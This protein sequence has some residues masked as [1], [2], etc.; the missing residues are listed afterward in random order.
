M[1]RFLFGC[2]LLIFVNST[3]AQFSEVRRCP[4]LNEINNA[5]DFY[6]THAND[7]IQSDWM[8]ISK[9][10]EPIIYHIT[11]ASTGW[12]AYMKTRVELLVYT[13][14]IVV[15]IPL[16]D[17]Y[18][19]KNDELKMGFRFYS[20]GASRQFIKTD[21]T[22]MKFEEAYQFYINELKNEGEIEFGLHPDCSSKSSHADSKYGSEND[23]EDGGLW[24]I[25]IGALSVALIAGIIKRRKKR[26]VKKDKKDKDKNEQADYI[27]QLNKESFNLNLDKSQ[28][29]QVK[30]WKITE[31]GK[32]L[33]NATIKL[34]CSEKALQMMP[35]SNTGILNSQLTLKEIPKN[36]QFNIIVTATAGGQTIQ[37][38]VRI[39][40][41]VE[42]KI[43]LETY[44]D[45]SRSLRPNTNQTISCY[46]KVV[47]E[48][49]ENID[50]LSQA[51]QFD[52]SYSDWLDLSKPVWDD[53]GWKAINI[54]A[55]NPDTN[56]YDPQTPKSVTLGV[57]VEYTEDGKDKRLENN[58]KIQLLDCKIDTDIEDI[59]FVANDK[60]QTIV[61]NAFIED[62]EE[63]KDWQ[64][65]AHYMKDYETKDAKPLSHISI[66]PVTETKVEIT[67]TGPIEVP[68]DNK[69]YLR[70]ML[71]IS[72][73]QKDEDPLQRELYVMV[74]K[75][76]LYIEE[77]LNEERELSFIAKGD[78]ERDIEFGLYKY[79]S[80]KEDV[81]S[82]EIGL[83][84]LSFELLNKKK[85]D[86]NLASVLEVN[87]E[88]LGLVTTIPR[89]RYTLNAPAEIPG[90]G[91]I[92]DL[93]YRVKAPNTEAEKKPELF[94]TDIT[95][96][97]QTLN[98]GKRYPTWQEAYDDCKYIIDKYVPA[99]PPQ[100]KLRAILEQRKTLLDAQGLTELRKKMW[101]VAYNLILAEGAE[102]YKD[103]DAW[104]SAI[105][106]TLEWTQWAGDI[107]FNVLMAIYFKKFGAVGALGAT[108]ASMLK[109]LMVEGIIFYA[110]EK[111]SA[112]DFADQQYQ[113]IVPLLMNVAKGRLISVDNIAYFVKNNRP[114]AWA[115]FISIEFVYNLWQTKSMIEAAKMT[116]RQIRDEYIIGKLTNHIIK[117]PKKIGLEIAER[118]KKIKYESTRVKKTLDKLEA[119]VRKN[120]IG[121]KFM[122]KGEVL[123]IMK[124]PAMVRTI[125]EHGTTTLKKAFDGPRKKIYQEHDRNLRRQIAKQEG[126]SA[127][128]LKVDDFRTPGTKGYNLNTDRDY[129]LLRRYKMANGKDV[130]LEVPR[131]KWLDKSYKELGKL[132]RKPANVSDRQWAEQL[133]QRGTDKYDAE[134]CADYSDHAI[135]PKTGK[136]IRIKPNILDVEAGK[137]TLIDPDDMGRMY[138]Q[139]VINAGDTP[140]AFAQAKKG[141]HTIKSVRKGY[142]KQG[143]KLK[144]LDPKLERAMRIIENQKVTVD[145]TPS[146]MAHTKKLLNDLG[147][148]NG[149][150]E[151]MDQISNEFKALK[152]VNKNS[153]TERFTNFLFN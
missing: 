151:V 121:G 136:K 127:R 40:T 41:G 16:H 28:Q 48:N 84:N 5:L 147:Y 3:R 133:Q 66:K 25:V 24:T 73:K 38:Q 102:G 150:N 12:E 137:G 120:R 138:K 146:D 113:K 4:T 115:I 148:K 1:K 49:G 140:E 55:S 134:A 21:G 87:F 33:T 54:Q 37:K 106:E 143:Y 145:A 23:D 152:N 46:A 95:L 72:A 111:G 114:I 17:N 39:S 86:K 101:S 132:T 124:D 89:G 118:P 85:E 149:V 42:M 18:Y 78:Y 79:D 100:D 60:Q 36:L 50:K 65:E 91:D 94:Q 29:L 83:K 130:W 88:L 58:L 126:I 52:A 67:L 75:V 30:V 71:I 32:S 99:G 26:N 7:N 90:Y 27:L 93:V 125:K 108:G 109:E 19:D 92:I 20:L 122:D 77:G 44:P 69:P 11:D 107:S 144:K 135:N 97:V 103:V 104:A 8:K 141:S 15:R 153:Y 57:F 10:S 63:L 131:K 31:K 112:Q 139:K 117:N 105:V 68:S 2:F 61:F 119:N 142:E 76:G 116:L 43:V 98:T 35:F 59:S 70:K 34:Q 47:D 74:S 123:E 6:K 56:V 22:P 53:D 110:Y 80:D 64:F 96:K 62:C 13:S 81:V 51:I 128:D 129:R 82:D 45:N 14:G 9:V